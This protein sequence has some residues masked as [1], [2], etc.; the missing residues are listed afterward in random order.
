MARAGAQ[1]PLGH[2]PGVP[3]AAVA[4]DRLAD[5]VRSLDPASRALLDLSLRRRIGDDAMAPLL[6]IDPF[7]LA[8]RRARTIERIA[9]ELGLDHPAG[10][11]DVRAALPRV[12]ASAW[13]LPPAIEAG[14]PPPAELPPAAAPPSS[15]IVPRAAP[16]HLAVPSPPSERPLPSRVRAV[17][18]AARAAAAAHPTTV[19]AAARGAFFACA[20]AVLGRAFSRRR[21]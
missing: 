21:R 12:P 19:R 5:C 3:R 6:R 17:A 13:C 14:P 8:W 15:Q 20:G 4:I 11:G 10:I 7:N 16:S 18:T 1:S 9:S 2:P